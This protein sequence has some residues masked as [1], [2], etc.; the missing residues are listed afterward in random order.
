MTETLH[1]YFPGK[2]GDSRERIQDLLR[3]R[4]MSQAELAEK[5]GLSESS[6]SRYLSGQ[7][8]KLSAENIVAIARVFKV[9]TDFLLCLTD[10]PYTTNYDIEKLGLSAKAGENLLKQ[11]VNPE[12]V[13]MLL[14]MPAFAELTYKLAQMR[15]GTKAA[16]VASMIAVFSQADELVYEFAQ[17]YSVDRQAA[18]QIINEIHGLKPVSAYELD[19]TEAEMLFRKIMQDFREGAKAYIEEAEKLT[20][21][22]MRRVVSNLRKHINHPEKQRGITGEDVVDSVIDQMKELDLKEEILVDLRNAMLPLFSKP[23]DLIEQKKQD[24]LPN[25]QSSDAEA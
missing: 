5:I 8:D 22:T 13:S 20:S 11:K 24:L 12:I 18:R 2:P 15:D 3:E 21:T 1:K 14:E 19:T 10:I 4:N 23:Q 6:L 16:G 7:T 9:T 17:Y 25:N